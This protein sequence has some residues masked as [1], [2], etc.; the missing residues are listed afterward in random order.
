MNDLINLQSQQ[1]E[2][3]QAELAKTRQMLSDAK[4]LLQNILNDWEV[5][6]A[7]TLDFTYLDEPTKAFDEAF[8]NPIEQIDNFFSK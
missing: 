8:N 7:Q 1:I 6:D 3:L 4:E 2:A 5:V